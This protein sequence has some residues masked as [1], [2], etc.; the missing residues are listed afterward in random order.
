MLNSGL[1]DSTPQLLLRVRLRFRKTD[2]LAAFFPL[3]AFFEQLNTLET[4][5]DVAFR[6]DRAGSP[7]TSML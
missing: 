7:E 2:D 1:N 6:D 3:A 4:L 5:Q